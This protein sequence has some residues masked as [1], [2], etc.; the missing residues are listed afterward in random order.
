MKCCSLPREP[1]RECLLIGF[2]IAFGSTEL[3]M[4]REQNELWRAMTALFLRD[5]VD[6]DSLAEGKLEDR[7]RSLW[8]VGVTVKS[9]S[10]IQHTNREEDLANSYLLLGLERSYSGTESC[11]SRLS[12]FD[13]ILELPSRSRVWSQT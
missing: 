7:Q 13:R 2:I 6:A 11:C 12:F 4:W 3:K 5:L 1:A 9:A 10:A 8:K